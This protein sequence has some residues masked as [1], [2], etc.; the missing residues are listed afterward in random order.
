VGCGRKVSRRLGRRDER[1]YGDAD[2]ADE[3]REE[4]YRG[5]EETEN[6]EAL[7]LGGASAPHPVADLDARWV[8]NDYS[9]DKKE[10]RLLPGWE[11]AFRGRAHEMGRSWAN[12]RLGRRH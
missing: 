5:Q 12:P 6:M 10:Q 2:K 7:V 1:F 3:S 9:E 4:S 8:A 11:S